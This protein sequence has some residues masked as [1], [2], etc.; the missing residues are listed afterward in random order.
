MTSKAIS[1]QRVLPAGVDEVFQAWSSSEMLAQWFVCNTTWTASAE[2]EFRIGGRYSIVMRSGGRI[3]G[4]AFG[5]YLEIEAPHRIVMSWSSAGEVVV[6]DSLLT[7]E[8][9]AVGPDTAL[10]LTHEIDPDSAAG[11]AHAVGWI[12][13][14]GSLHTFLRAS[15]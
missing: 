4:R 11:Q 13:T 12:G 9:R 3:I 7:I 14:L 6:R 1:L 8:L 10:T 2:C 15:T 5:T